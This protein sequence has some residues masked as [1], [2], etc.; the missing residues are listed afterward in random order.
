M[1]KIIINT[2]IGGDFDDLL[3]LLLAI[4]SPEIDVLGVVTTKEH[5]R[6]KAKFAK[7]ILNIAGKETI[8]VFYDGQLKNKGKGYISVYDYSFLTQSDL[9]F[10][11]IEFG[12]SNNGIEFIIDTIEKNPGEINLVS[13]APN[14]NLA[15]VIKINTDVV[16]KIKSI[17]LMGGT[18]N[19]TDENIDKPEHN[20]MRDRKSFNLVTNQEIPIYLVTRDITHDLFLKTSDFPI[21]PKSQL[22]ISNKI[23]NPKS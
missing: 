14:T 8:P 3:A 5:I 4:N 6:D 11:D 19:K 20:Y 15:S 23:S 10:E 16:E 22:R 7:K 9:D 21:N 17:Y 1:E 18:L 2:D 12:I 13:L